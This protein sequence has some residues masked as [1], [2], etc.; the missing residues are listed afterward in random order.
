MEDQKKKIIDKCKFKI[1]FYKNGIEN[2][3]KML[4]S[5]KILLHTEESLLK[6]L[7][8]KTGYEK[9]LSKCFKSKRYE[10]KIIKEANRIIEEHSKGEGN[11]GRKK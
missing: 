8:P 7:I 2:F 10:P 1:C 11:N 6:T 5:F 9:F 4:K 3:E